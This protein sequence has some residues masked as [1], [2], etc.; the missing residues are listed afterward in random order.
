M[1]FEFSP[2][3]IIQLPEVR[4]SDGLYGTLNKCLVFL[5]SHFY[6]KYEFCYP[7]LVKI[8]MVYWLS[9]YQLHFFYFSATILHL[10]ILNNFKIVERSY[11]S[12]TIKSKTT[13]KYFFKIGLCEVTFFKV[14][15]LIEIVLNFS[16]LDF[17]ML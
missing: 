4:L 16:L 17:Y 3:S 15:Q 7:I 1:K 11:W 6:I 2:G 12:L 10:I 14:L 5:F 13:N 9:N 8:W